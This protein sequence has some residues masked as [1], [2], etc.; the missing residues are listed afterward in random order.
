MNL[1]ELPML[2][3]VA[4]LMY[5]VAGRVDQTA[6][7]LAWAYVGLRAIHSVIHLSYNKVTHRL[8]AYATSNFVLLAFW[9]MFFV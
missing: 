3:Y 4:G 1:L 7:V 9:V 5:Y 6:L 2:F 8:V